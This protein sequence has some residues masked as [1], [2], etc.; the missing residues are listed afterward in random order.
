MPNFKGMSVSEAQNVALEN[1]LNISLDGSGI[2]ISQDIAADSQIE[3]G[4]VINLTLKSQL[5]GGW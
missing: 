3:I 2:V 1:N 5:N 4:S